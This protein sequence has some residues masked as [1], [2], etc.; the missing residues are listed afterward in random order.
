MSFSNCSTGPTVKGP[1][2]VDRCDGNVRALGRRAASREPVCE[3][4]LCGGSG[5][6]AGVEEARSLAARRTLEPGLH[7]ARSPAGPRPPAERGRC[8]EQA[9]QLSNGRDQTVRRGDSKFGWNDRAAFENT[10]R[11]IRRGRLSALENSVRG[12]LVDRFH[13]RVVHQ[14]A[15]F[16]RL[17]TSCTSRGELHRS[18]RCVHSRALEKVS[19]GSQESEGRDIR[20]RSS[21]VHARHHS[22]G[23]LPSERARR[24]SCGAGIRDGS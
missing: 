10:I 12:P 16:E 14:S 24:R 18:K 13:G 2:R 17:Q 20:R 5:A 11:G 6:F 9:G 4:G 7:S 22:S 8:D 15:S 21:A 19:G 3:R 23:D 1:D